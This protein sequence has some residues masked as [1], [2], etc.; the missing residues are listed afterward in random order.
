MPPRKNFPAVPIAGRGAKRALRPGH[1]NGAEKCGCGVLSLEGNCPMLAD[2]AC[3]G[4]V[5]FQEVHRATAIVL[6]VVLV[7]LVHAG[8]SSRLRHGLRHHLEAKRRS[9]RMSSV[10]TSGE[11]PTAATPAASVGE[12]GESALRRPEAMIRNLFPPCVDPRP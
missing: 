3:C 2:W 7:Q 12:I 9:F 5:W 4:P 10:A 11:A 8:L 1:L 6:V